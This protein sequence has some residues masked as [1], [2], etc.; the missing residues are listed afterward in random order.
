MP[1]NKLVSEQSKTI[2]F[3]GE[4]RT[5]RSENGQYDKFSTGFILWQYKTIVS[6]PRFNTDASIERVSIRQSLFRVLPETRIYRSFSG[7]TKDQ[8]CPW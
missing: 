4:N 1:L 7:T 6:N 8:I 3:W 2:S 5:N